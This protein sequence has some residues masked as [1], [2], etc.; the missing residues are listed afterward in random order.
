MIDKEKAEEYII[1][2]YYKERLEEESRD[3]IL[4]DVYNHDKNEL[5]AYSDGFKEGYEL[6]YNEKFENT[7]MK[8]EEFDKYLKLVKENEQLIKESIQT[9]ID[10]AKARDRISELEKELDN[11]KAFKSHCKEIE[12]NE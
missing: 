1:N 10:F 9:E 8:A 6:G 5:Q 12:E 4:E 11:Y 3:V 2:K 7:Y